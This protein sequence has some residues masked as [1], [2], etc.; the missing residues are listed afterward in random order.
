LVFD[1]F[2]PPSNQE[3]ETAFAFFSQNNITDLILDIRY[4]GGGDLNV[5]P[6]MASYIAGS[7]KFKMPLFKLSFNDKNSDYNQI[8]NFPTVSFPLNLTKLVTIC[9]RGTAS[10]SEDLI[11]GLKP[12]LNVISV[13]DTT[14]GKPVG[15][16]GINY[17]T[18]YMFWPIS[19]SIVNSEDQGEFYDGIVPEKYVVDD[20][21]HDWHDR[22]ELCLKEAIYYLENG[23]ISSKGIY[24]YQQS[25]QFSEKPEGINNAFILRK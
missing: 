11:N 23:S 5:L 16:V 10:A 22:N 3:L 2:I 8:F 12:Y 13:G 6:I 24:D 21:T 17:K 4:N 25:V 15:M 1:Q 20:I 9:S 19:F 18:D 7:T 14:D